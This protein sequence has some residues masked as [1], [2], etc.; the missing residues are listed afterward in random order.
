MTQYSDAPIF[1]DSKTPMSYKSFYLHTLGCKVNWCDSDSI[2]VEAGKTGWKRVE[3]ICDAQISVVN[4]C[5]VTKHAAASAR[6]IIRRIRRENPSAYIIVTGCYAKTDGEII[7]K[8]EEVD[9]IVLPGDEKNLIEKMGSAAERLAKK[10]RETKPPLKEG[11]YA[12]RPSSRTRTFIKVQ[13]GCDQFCAYCIVPF[14]RG[15]AKSFPA[16]KILEKIKRAEEK[17][18]REIVLTGIH[19]AAY[20]SDDTDHPLRS[21]NI[22]GLVQHIAE[23]S[24]IPRIRI[25]SLDANAID[26]KFCELFKK[27]PAVMPHLHIPLQSGS[28]KILELM[29]RPVKVSG[30]L[31]AANLFLSSHPLAAVST[32]V[33]VGL[34]GETEEDFYKT[35]SLVEKIPFLKVHIFQF[36]P[37]PGTGAAKMKELFVQPSEVKRREKIL[38]EK[39]E[40]SARLC[41]KK[42]ETEKL[43]V[44]IEN[45]KNRLWEGLS[46]N[47]LRVKTTAKTGCNGAAVEQNS[48]VTLDMSSPENR[49]EK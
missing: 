5:T 48:I 31:R 21:Y 19:L 46:E 40:T 23:N 17:N 16:N 44:L 24:E 11:H 6:K 2:A 28:N 47:Y 7:S 20:N 42:F 32:D 41:R 35:V 34:P 43:N 30:F 8:M 33:M 13:D 36:S 49:W 15:R 38:M 4:T 9:E 1:Q 14:A 3:D 22:S 10:H 45:K 12:G 26:E 25:S 18:V 27:Y 29:N 39:A 37:R